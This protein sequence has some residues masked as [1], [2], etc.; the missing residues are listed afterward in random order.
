MADRQNELGIGGRQIICNL[1]VMYVRT[2][3]YHILCGY[4]ILQDH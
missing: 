4:V 1:E 2:S 3:K